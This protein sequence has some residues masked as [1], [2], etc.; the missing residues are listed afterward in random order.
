M[1][2]RAALDLQSR[3]AL[4]PGMWRDAQLQQDIMRFATRGPGILRVNEL[5]AILNVTAPEKKAAVLWAVWRRRRI[6][7]ATLARLVGHVF[8]CCK[9][10]AEL[11]TEEQ[12]LTLFSQ[13][14]F[15]ADGRPA[16]PPAGP[17]RLWRASAPAHIRR[18]SWTPLPRV[19]LD[20]AAG[21]GTGRPGAGRVWT[22]VV[23]PHQVLCINDALLTHPGEIE[24]VIDTRGLDITEAEQTNLRGAA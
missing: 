4:W 12:W 14:G 2:M 1:K 16:P 20:Y 17:R 10:P 6:T 7:P 22:A 15:T 8:I 21:K 3:P 24:W 18:M 5:G 9:Q 23:Q 11:L 13:A 19:A